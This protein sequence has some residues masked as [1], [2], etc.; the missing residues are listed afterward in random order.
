MLQNEAVLRA[1]NFWENLF[2]EESWHRDVLSD[3]RHRCSA[4][5]KT[6]SIAQSKTKIVESMETKEYVSK[7]VDF[8]TLRLVPWESQDSFSGFIV[9]RAAERFMR[10]DDASASTAAQS[11]RSGQHVTI[12]SKILKVATFFT[13]EFDNFEPEEGNVVKEVLFRIGKAGT[14]PKNR[15]SDLTSGGNYAI[16]WND[17]T[18]TFQSP[19]SVRTFKGGQDAL[20]AW[21]SSLNDAN[22][23]N[24]ALRRL[25]WWISDD[26]N[27]GE[28]KQNPNRGNWTVDNGDLETWLS[29]N[30]ATRFPEE[31]S[32][33][34]E[35]TKI[36]EL[37]NIGIYGEFGANVEGVKFSSPFDILEI[38]DQGFHVFELKTINWR[39]QGTWGFDVKQLKTQ[40][41]Q[42]IQLCHL[43]GG[44]AR[45]AKK[46]FNNS[47][48]SWLIYVHPQLRLLS[49]TSPLKFEY[50]AQRHTIF[51]DTLMRQ[52]RIL[53]GGAD[54]ILPGGVLISHSLPI[55]KERVP[56]GSILRS[57]PFTGLNF[58]ANPSTP[59]VV[60]Y[61]QNGL[62]NKLLL[63]ALNSGIQQL[64]ISLV[65]CN[66]G[67]LDTRCGHSSQ[68]SG[69]NKNTAQICADLAIPTTKQVSKLV[70]ESWYSSYESAHN[71][72]TAKIVYRKKAINRYIDYHICEAAIRSD[73][74]D[75]YR[76]I[77]QHFKR[78]GQWGNYDFTN[79]SMRTHWDSGMIQRAE[80]L[81]NILQSTI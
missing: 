14:R 70:I 47:T 3:V 36:D 6:V 81:L 78:T 53:N 66:F 35:L 64:A 54:T 51:V 61:N 30:D 42:V 68:L 67:D 32:F 44:N 50:I 9:Q 65:S 26:G 46:L 43:R 79:K 25:R 8:S 59:F 20:E 12:L 13:E 76:A 10:L 11:L 63:Q 77:C 69:Q 37:D 52:Y 71:S 33:E 80:A 24:L 17:N 60:P 7:R 21:N 5:A 62:N 29:A 18:I 31:E 1:L 41:Q 4:L 22:G 2:A 28:S 39:A 72:T 16:L 27:S 75:S 57:T 74:A 48:W 55:V 45:D 38:H 49:P 56:A 23:L 19:S 15:V 58:T 73:F 34:F 40:V